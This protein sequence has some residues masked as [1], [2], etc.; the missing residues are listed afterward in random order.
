MATKAA[1]TT[2]T[3]R[4][5][6]SA[7]ARSKGVSVEEENALRMRHGAGVAKSAPLPRKAAEGSEAGDE[8]LIVEMQLLKAYRAHVASQQAKSKAAP[9]G[10][11]AHAPVA[12]NRAKDK[13][14]RALRKKR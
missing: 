8:L 7:L 5:V 11:T 3:A 10:R 1:T 9:K 13:I 6:Q 4:E 12:N 14:V 2:L